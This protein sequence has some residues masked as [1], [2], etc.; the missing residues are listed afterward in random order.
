MIDYNMKRRSG[1]RFFF[2]W[3]VLVASFIILFFNA[4]ASFTIGVLF[5]PMINDFGWSRGTF[6]ISFFLNMAIYA[7]SLIVAGRAY[8]RY[9]PKW[10]I[11]ISTL[12]LSGG[13]MGIFFIIEFW[14]YLIL[15]GI[16][17]AAGMGGTTAPIFG[18]I[19]S[20]WFERYRGLAISLAIAGTGVGQ[21]VLVPLITR[22]LLLQGWRITFFLMGLAMLIVNILL[23]LLVVKGN[24]DDLGYA[25]LGHLEDR[26]ARSIIDTEVS[27]VDLQDDLTLFEAMKTKSFWFFS[28]VMVVCGSGDFFISMHLVPFVTDH[29]VSATL[30]GNMFAWFGLLSLVGVI[31]A[32]PS[33]DL[34]GAKIPIA[35]T[36]LMRVLLLLIIIKYKNEMSFYVFSLGFGFT[37]LITAP[38][39]TMLSGKMF[40]F[41]NVGLI[42][43]FIT[44]IHHIAGGAWAYMGGVFFDRTGS[45]QSMFIIS[46]IM[47]A[48]AVFSSLF[49][50]EEKHIKY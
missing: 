35:L 3:Y 38:I 39:A 42:S 1:E 32:G 15:Y 49:I 20:K 31:I 24:P 50:R 9:G 28:L 44:T 48:I 40:G 41:S 14:Q 45:Y 27:T 13:F 25:P 17:A 16:F 22:I 12:L 7:L 37:L 19:L 46:M 2:G 11:I 6:S 43:G 26:S 29:G 33:T 4:G 10:V 18:A 23:A 8:D 21:F 47:A 5:K 36:F 34:M 30:A